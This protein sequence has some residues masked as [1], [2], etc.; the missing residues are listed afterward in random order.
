MS[1]ADSRGPPTDQNFLNFMRFLAKS[2]KFVC[3]RPPGGLVPPPTENPASAPV[4][5]G[6]LNLN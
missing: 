6:V 2:G 4:C 3:W 1:D 5:H